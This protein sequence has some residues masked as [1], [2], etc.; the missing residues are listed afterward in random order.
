MAKKGGW[1]FTCMS[2]ADVAL[3]VALLHAHKVAD[4]AAE[5]EHPLLPVHMERH[6]AH[7]LGVELR[8]EAANMAAAGESARERDRERETRERE[9]QC[10][11]PRRRAFA[12]WHSL[13]SLESLEAD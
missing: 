9:T 11:K 2:A 12:K 8:L 4:A 3:H 5:R 1:G 13:A 10:V 7:E 6:V